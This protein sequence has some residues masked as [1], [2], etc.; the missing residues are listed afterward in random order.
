MCGITGWIDRARPM[1]DE[2]RTVA[3]MAS[4]MACAGQD[5]TATWASAHVVLGRC[6]HVTGPDGAPRWSDVAGS[7]V[8]RSGD[9]VVAFDG[10]IHNR[11]ELREHLRHGGRLPQTGSDAELVLAAY[12]EHGEAALDRLAGMYAFAVWDARRDTLLLVRDRLG[13][14]PLYWTRCDGGTLFGSE[15]KAVLA[16]PL[17][18][19]EVDAEGLAALFTVAIKPP[20]AGVY[21]N[22]REVR[23][24]H[25]VRVDGTGAHEHRYWQVRTAPHTDDL[26]TTVQQV[27]RLLGRAVGEQ[28][29]SDVPLVALLSGGIDSSAIVGLAART[30]ADEGRELAT[31]S[32]DFAGAEEDFRADALHLSRDAPFVRLVADHVGTRHSEVVVA[33]PSLLEELDTTLRARDMPGVGDLDASL[34]LLF[35]QVRKQAA[36]A[37]SGEGA[38]DLFGGY[39]WFLA[40]SGQPT[41]NFP[42]SAGVSNRNAQL[43]PELRAVLDL[44]AYV[45]DTYADALAEVPHLDGESGAD[46]RLREVSHLQLTR[47]LP[48]LLDRKDRMSRAN[49]LEV[50]LPFC[51]HRLVEYLWN[52]PWAY[53]RTGGQEKGLLRAAVADLLP[54]A[55]VNRPKSGF[56]FGQSPAYLEAIRRTVRD[57]V[58]DPSSPAL[59][60]VDV[61]SVRAMLDSDAWFSGT[62]T[63]PPWLPRVIQLDHW[64]REYRVSVVL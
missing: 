53:R 17:F 30:L 16:H 57:I 25:L 39:P 34:L 28:L 10:E 32:L 8:S 59:G 37:L 50:R 14:K 63:P 47:F 60:L 52:V 18:P 6:G 29:V 49:G 43:S 13:I 64:L 27:R 45:A 56:P 19:A 33:A 21:R 9:V 62:F 1:A 2:T 26:P 46:R 23:P 31:Y 4:S 3:S 55:V 24:G 44:D 11:G 12:L 5:A 38:D 51:D 20:G 40:E 7:A 48:F 42:W 35:R 22:L 61:G 36:V 54:P 58:D 15:P 41:H